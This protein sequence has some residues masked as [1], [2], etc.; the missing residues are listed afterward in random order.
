MT[1]R[2]PASTGRPRDISRSSRSRATL[3]SSL[4]LIGSITPGSTRIQ[5]RR[6][7][8]GRTRPRYAFTPIRRAHGHGHADQCGEWH[9]CQLRARCPRCA[10]QHGVLHRAGTGRHRL[11]FF[12]QVDPVSQATYAN[13]SY[14]LVWSRGI[15]AVNAALISEYYE[16]EYV[17][18]PQTASKT[19]WVL[20]FPTRR[21]FVTT[22]AA[23]APFT[24]PFGDPSAHCVIAG[25]RPHS[26]S[27][28]RRSPARPFSRA[29][30]RSF[31]RALP[32]CSAPQTR[33]AGTRPSCPS[34]W[35]RRPEES[36]CRRISRT[37][38]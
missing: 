37:A 27:G 17:L 34:A 38:A 33:S 16:N 36:T 23:Q 26:R 20:T 13:T 24:A 35:R 3:S 9:G 4:T 29:P 8:G 12:P 30:P 10:H 11:R 5:L 6:S 22:S 19:D 14:R 18:D 31:C 32:T 25:P 1:T 2:A 15:D 21:F 28:T 7:A